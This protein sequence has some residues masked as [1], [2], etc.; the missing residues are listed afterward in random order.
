M[1]LP[2]AKNRSGDV[3]V[4]TGLNNTV[5][6]S[7]S[8]LTTEVELGVWFPKVQLPLVMPFAEGYSPIACLA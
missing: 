3:N 2:E 6:P 4:T 7:T 8:P 5:T 1:R